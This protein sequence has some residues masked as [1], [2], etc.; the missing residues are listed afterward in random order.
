[1]VQSASA[2]QEQTE[3]THLPSPR[4][5]QKASSVQPPPADRQNF[6]P[7]SSLPVHVSGRLQSASFVQANAQLFDPPSAKQSSL[8]FSAV[9]SAVVAHCGLLQAP[10]TQV[11]LF[12]YLFVGQPGSPGVQQ[13]AAMAQGGAQ[14]P[15]TT[16]V[17]VLEELDPELV[18]VLA[19]VVVAVVVA[20]PVP[21][22]ALPPALVEELVD[23]PPAPEVVVAPP[24]LVAAVP[25]SPHETPAKRPIPAT[26]AILER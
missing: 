22:E 16:P 7:L 6:L 17:P 25:P 1:M 10:L 5:L 15:Y 14:V 26:R 9:Q 24:V 12:G 8:G 19:L 4:P 3:A 13:S 21:V 20:P 23:A 2:S 18:V 11:G